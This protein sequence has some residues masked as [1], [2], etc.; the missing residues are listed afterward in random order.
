MCGIIG[1]FNHP[2][3]AAM[4]AKGLAVM[5]NRGKD[6]TNVKAFSNHALGHNLHAIVDTIPQPIHLDGCHLVFNGEIYNWEGLKKKHNL[7]ARNDAEVLIRL[8]ASTKDVH[9]TL[10]ELDGVYAFC[11]YDSTKNTVWAAR[12]VIGVRPLWFSYG[13][14]LALASE[15]KALEANGIYDSM[16]LNPRNMIVYDV[17]KNMI[18]YEPR[19]FFDITP[20]V[21][22]TK[23]EIAQQLDRLL[24]AAVRKRKTVKKVGL[25][26]SGGV[27]SLL[28][29]ALLIR[30]KINFTA[31]CAV[32]SE[33]GLKQADDVKGA[34]SAARML[35]IKLK[36]VTC[37]VGQTE[38]MVKKIVR[39][40]EATDVVK[41][42]VSLPIFAAAQAAAKDGCKI[43]FS[44]IGL[45]T[46]F[47]SYDRP[48]QSSA[49]L[50][51]DCLSQLRRL[52]ERD[53]YREDVVIMSS[54][55]E[56]R[57]PFLDKDLVA[58][59][60]R[61]PSRLKNGGARDKALVRD[62]ARTHGILPEFAEKRR[63]S[64][65][66]SSGFDKA[67]ERLAKAEKRT[68]TGYLN[69]LSSEHN[70]RLGALWS[71]GKDSAYAT[72]LMKNHH[73]DVACLLTVKSRNPDSFMFHT[74]TIDLARLHGK[75][76]GIPVVIQQTAGT[77]EE[78]LEDLKRL[79]EKAQKQHRIQG[80]IVGALFSTYQRDRIDKVAD[81]LG[82]KV[83]S[84]LWHK[85]QTQEVKEILDNGFEFV[86]TKIA[87]DGL[88]KAWLGRQ[89]TEKD[90]QKLVALNQK[91]GMNIAGEGGEY[92]TL[93]LDCPLFKKRVSV[94]SAEIKQLD[95]Y[96]AVYRVKKAVLEER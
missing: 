8:L 93:V 3:S 71:T 80:V 30:Q 81:A 34:E 68:K 53:L 50:N 12:D 7:V 32:F 64:P 73:Y 78:E 56:L 96:T 6:A 23:E 66:Y 82:L 57:E 37:T 1:V 76:M 84:P 91:A 31:Y 40:I 14:C 69:D 55:L 19:K 22:G 62:V 79:L 52:Y 15:R 77:K 60:L 25:L 41:V 85:D 29:A 61:I 2:L 39:L 95:K 54:T 94:R 26:F 48:A 11:F 75:A 45:D 83:F 59:A 67:L 33:P 17:A 88:D 92:E 42:G 28:L 5:Q 24:V 13:D 58:Y 21:S 10:D 43:V 86:M 35:G 70:L 49:T 4:A 47:G 89:I 46:V 87:A 18:A 74:P 90:L 65:Q 72:Y 36:M 27:D 38:K 20:E 63:K 16:E 9:R 44:G 51:Q